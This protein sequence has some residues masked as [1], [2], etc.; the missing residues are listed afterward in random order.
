MHEAAGIKTISTNFFYQCNNPN[1]HI[2]G[3]IQNTKAHTPAVLWQRFRGG[4]STDTRFRRNSRVI[5][6]LE[7]DGFLFL[8]S[9]RL[10]GAV[11]TVAAAMFVAATVKLC[12]IL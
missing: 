1:A 10:G 6:V 2:R 12:S 8:Y 3:F 5:Q 9:P 4:G 11:L 7:R